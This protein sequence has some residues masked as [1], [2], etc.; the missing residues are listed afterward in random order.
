MFV[1][2]QFFYIRWCFFFL[3]SRSKVL[4]AVEEVPLCIFSL[5]I[6]Q[7]QLRLLFQ[8]ME[9]RERGA[10]HLFECH[11]NDGGRSS[12]YSGVV[13]APWLL[14]Q[15]SLNVRQGGR[16]VRSIALL[17]WRS[18]DLF[19]TS[20]FIDWYFLSRVEM[21]DTLL[22]QVIIERYYFYKTALPRY[23]FWNWMS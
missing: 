11:G 20:A 21:T 8:N 16:L 19:S 23:L 5:V 14:C 1:I 17:D 10:V 9:Y 13:A 3:S 15:G 12:R 18:T 2:I 7:C 6:L 4:F 22:K